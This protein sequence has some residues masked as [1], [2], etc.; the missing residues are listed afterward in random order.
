[1]KTA[2]TVF[3]SI[4]LFSLY[5]QMD[6]TTK[7]KRSFYK[8][9]QLYHPS[10][11]QLNAEQFLAIE[12]SAL[13]LGPEDE[14]ILNQ[15]HKSKT[16]F[17]RLKYQQ[18]YKGLKIYGGVYFLHETNE[19][20]VKSSGS[21]FP[22]INLKVKP[23][24]KVQVAIE[25]AHEFALSEYHIHYKEIENIRIED[26][27][28]TII[29]AKFPQF[30]GDYRLTHQL[31]LEAEAETTPIR[32]R[33][34]VDAKTGK[35]VN[36]F[37]EICSS[38]PGKTKTRYY[39]ERSITTDSVG[40]NEY[41]L[42]D[43]TRGDGVYTLDGMDRNTAA[44]FNYNS[45]TDD[46]NYWDN[47][48]EDFDEVAG[49]LHFCTSS[50]Y[51][52]MMEKFNWDGLDGE[53]GA[54]VAIAHVN[55]KY[56]AN[57]FWNGSVT[58]YGNG[59]CN[60]YGPLTTLDVVAHEF[61]HGHIDF[62]SDLV[63]QDESGAL[64]ESIADIFG[65]TVE[66]AYDAGN[67]T[68]EIGK[69]FVLD[70]TEAG[71]R[72]MEDPHLKNDPSFY[73]GEDWEF[74]SS[75]RGGVHTNSGV[76]NHWYY[77]LVQGGVGT[78][79]AMYDFN[80]PALGWE[81]AIDIVYEVQRGYLTMSSD[82]SV[83]LVSTIEY[84]KEL[85]GEGSTEYLA[86]IEA[87]KAVGLEIGFNDFDLALEEVVE[88][89]FGCP[90]EEIVPSVIIRNVGN[91]TYVTGEEISISYLLNGGV[92]TEESFDLQQVLAPSDSV[93]YEFKTPITFDPNIARDF[94]IR[95]NKIDDIEVNNSIIS[96]IRFNENFGQDLVMRDFQFRLDDECKPEEIRAYRIDLRNDGCRPITSDDVV[97]LKVTTDLQEETF[98]YI[99]YNDI[100]PGVNVISFRSF[101]GFVFIPGFTEFSAELIF[102]N[103]LD[104]TNNRIESEFAFREI[105][106]EDYVQRFEDRSFENDFEF[107]IQT[108]LAQDSL[109]KY[110]GSERLAIAPNRIYSSV[111]RCLSVEDFYDQNPEA[112][113]LTA[114]IDVSGMEDPVLSL[115]IVQIRNGEVI[116]DI[117]DAYR[118]MVFITTDSVDYPLIY[119]Q[120]NGDII[121]HILDLN[122]DY[123]GPLEINTMVLSGVESTF[124][125]G[126]DSLDV[127]MFDNIEIYDRATKVISPDVDKFTVF[128]TLLSD[129]VNFSHP[130]QNLE[131]RVDI[132]STLGQ[133]L[134][135][136]KG[137]G[138]LEVNMSEFTTGFYF[139]VISVGGEVVET[140]R[141]IKV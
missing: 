42:I 37:T 104:E 103:D 69:R 40:P 137:Y 16:G 30:S 114:C 56:Y 106:E 131:Y 20:I 47:A 140:D 136:E 124:D 35:I 117:D 119:N 34:F 71:I 22:Q 64:N 92:E 133:K 36:H 123:I 89:Y 28:L 105:L 24:L 13:G 9:S 48:N 100:E 63:Y 77:L 78:N 110:R 121:N 113:S 99:V 15:T 134:L 107:N 4:C 120:K 129:N 126:L 17:T 33:I 102:V 5:G 14:L 79:E 135:S 76:F 8:S 65:K 98:N 43:T 84:T 97:M 58:S 31:M 116:L 51:D 55:S 108:W 53:G 18:Y 93:L 73:H 138:F 26:L 112:S 32:E 85:Y 45:F 10:N 125:A 96:E 3:F 91:K 25:A 95:L 38:S 94:Q 141:L 81:K 46:D 11:G 54:L 39:G 111:N 61:T 90:D 118:S 139:Y 41:R 12:A 87:W 72:S 68:W 62:G 60:R 57:A 128:P 132:Y 82:Y 29:D 86:V 6:Q 127:V 70:Q 1:M 44:D 2:I 75:D 130:D 74:G 27:G 122:N 101:G 19:N 21:L 88:E 23:T 7:S 109:L 66:Y 52:Y 83:A 80:V 59:N 115:D 49:D 67:F 50:Y